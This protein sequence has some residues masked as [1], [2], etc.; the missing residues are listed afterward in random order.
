MITRS[1]ETPRHAD[2]AAP[3]H[4]VS[5]GELVERLDT[6]RDRGLSGFVL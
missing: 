6:D 3:C 1:P 5:L 2:R 4:A